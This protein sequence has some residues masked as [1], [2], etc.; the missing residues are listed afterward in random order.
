MHRVER[1]SDARFPFRAG[2]LPADQIVE[3]NQLAT[4]SESNRRTSSPAA[5]AASTRAEFRNRKNVR[6]ARL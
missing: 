2:Q 3:K 1:D 4:V 6:V 5:P